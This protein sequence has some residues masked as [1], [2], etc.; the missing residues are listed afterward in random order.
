M[1][2]EKVLSISRSL[3]LIV[4]GLV[5]SSCASIHESAD[6]ERHRY[7]QVTEPY[8]RN[9]VLYF[10]V[11]FSAQFPDDD[12][13]AEAIRMKWLDAWLEQRKLCGGNGYEIVTRRPFDTMEYN[14]AHHDVRYEFKCGSASAS[15]SD[16]DTAD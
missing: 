10:D 2:A 9:D 12:P 5:L 4:I 3:P 1:P 16:T 13:E 8:D 11:T 15:A 7:S 14:A 6:F